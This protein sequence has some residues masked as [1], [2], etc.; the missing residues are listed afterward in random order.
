VQEPIEKATLVCTDDDEVR[1]VAIGERNATS[2]KA[3]PSSRS[4]PRSCARAG[5]VALR[6]SRHG[7]RLPE[8]ARGRAPKLEH[9]RAEHRLHRAA[10]KGRMK[11]QELRE[12]GAGPRAA[13]CS[14]VATGQHVSMKQSIGHDRSQARWTERVSRRHT[15]SSLLQ[16]S[17]RWQSRSLPPRLACVLGHDIGVNSR[18]AK[19]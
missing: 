10:A 6:S 3:R 7:P 18:R 17:S 9:P 19:N 8:C 16:P 14:G 11:L 15:W 5:S 13:P 4:E 1:L 2:S 12:R